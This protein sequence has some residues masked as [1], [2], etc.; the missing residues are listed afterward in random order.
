MAKLLQKSIA[1]DTLI[2]SE[3]FIKMNW[4]VN[5]KSAQFTLYFGWYG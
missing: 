4:D 3:V 5:A 2:V 1:F